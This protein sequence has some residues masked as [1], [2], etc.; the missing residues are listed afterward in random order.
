MPTLNQKEA[1]AI[2]AAQLTIGPQHLLDQ[3][4][5]FEPV[6]AP[7]I[8][9]YLDARTDENGKRTF[10][11]FVRKHLTERGKSYP[12]RSAERAS[13]E[14]DFVRIARYLEDGIPA[15]AQGLAIFACSAARDYFKV[16]HFNVPFERNR[17]LVS[18]R[19][20]VYPLARLIDQ[21]RPYAVVLADTNRA[22]IFVFT[23][24]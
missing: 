19:P 1:S 23:A 3:L 8:S 13:F 6:P 14:E 17:L 4:L 22:H 18:D 9:L 21:Y 24:G 20:H 15:E 16:G 5:D 2:E 12:M 10:L 7:F 11:P